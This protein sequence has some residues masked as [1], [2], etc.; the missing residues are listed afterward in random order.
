M[1]GG[2]VELV[3]VHHKRSGV[4]R[5]QIEGTGPGGV[6]RRRGRPRRAEDVL[7]VVIR[8][9]V[10]SAQYQR[11]KA[12]ADLNHQPVVDVLRDAADQ[13][14]LDCSDEMIFDMAR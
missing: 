5:R 9:R 8:F 14:A 13:V 10:S 4:D 12:V 6:E 2:V 3:D 7:D 1:I 11:L